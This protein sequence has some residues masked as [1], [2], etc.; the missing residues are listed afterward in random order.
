MPA[1]LRRRGYRCGCA[2]ACS[3]TSIPCTA[4][5]STAASAQPRDAQIEDD[6]DREREQDEEAR[7][8]AQASDAP[9]RAGASRTASRTLRSRPGS[10]G[11]RRRCRRGSRRPRRSGRRCPASR[12]A[13]R[14]ATPDADAENENGEQQATGACGLER[15]RGGCLH[16]HGENTRVVAALVTRRSGVVLRKVAD[17]VPVSTMRSCRAPASSSS[18]AASSTAMR[19]GRRSSRSTSDSSS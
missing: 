8:R 6:E 9:A 18:T 10:G 1:P 15:R 12:R 2:P 19:P 16:R 4:H 11:R 17:F 13:S 3:T 5:Q 14:G 7:R